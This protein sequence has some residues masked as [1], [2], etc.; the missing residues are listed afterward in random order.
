M[1]RR[2]NLSKLIFSVGIVLLMSFFISCGSGGGDGSAVSRV[3]LDGEYGNVYYSSEGGTGER[4]FCGELTFTDGD[5]DVVYHEL[6][7]SDGDDLDSATI[8]YAAYSDGTMNLTGTEGEITRGIISPDGTFVAFVNTDFTDDGDVEIGVA[9]KKS[10][11]MSNADLD[12]EYLYVNYYDNPR[13]AY[14]TM[15][16]NG[17]GT[18]TYQ[19]I[20]DSDGSGPMAM[21]ESINYAV[22]GDGSLSITRPTGEVDHGMVSS[23]GSILAVANT[24]KTDPSI[25]IDIAIKKSSGMSNAFLDDDY[26]GVNYF[27][28]PLPGTYVSTSYGLLGLDGDG[29][30]SYEQLYTSESEKDSLDV[31]YDV[32]PDGTSTFTFTEDVAGDAGVFDGIISADG[33]VSV[34]VDTDDTDEGIGISFG[35][36]K[37]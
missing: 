27:R 29:G 36:R 34:F 32:N 3:Y 18:A 13:T 6:F 5:K 15:T 1:I 35:I 37:Q 26:I 21:P 7:N 31:E 12:G 2:C 17:N 14:G 22:S 9:I 23:D 4:T 33:D 20:D 8:T 10:T 16:F 25:G 24:V 11:G 30:G 19:R 28:E